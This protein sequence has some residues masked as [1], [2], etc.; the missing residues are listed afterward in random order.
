MLILS[1]E[2]VYAASVTNK[3]RFRTIQEKQAKNADA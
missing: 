1:E 3:Y 2:A